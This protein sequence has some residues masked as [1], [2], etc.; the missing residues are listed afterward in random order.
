[1]KGRSDHKVAEINWAGTDYIIVVRPRESSIRPCISY[2]LL[3]HGSYNS[4]IELQYIPASLEIL[5]EQ[6][7]CTKRF[8]HCAIAYGCMFTATSM[9]VHLHWYMYNMY[10]QQS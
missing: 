9:A 3:S 7:C 2:M 10:H 4:V 5:V 6:H 8:F 1:M